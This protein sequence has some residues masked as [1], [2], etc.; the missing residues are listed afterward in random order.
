[1]NPVPGS[2][3]PTSREQ[4]GKGPQKKGKGE[5][6]NWGG[7][8]GRTD[9]PKRETVFKGEL[10]APARES[11]EKKGGGVLLER[12]PGGTGKGVNPLY[13]ARAES[14]VRTKKNG[15]ETNRNFLSGFIK[16]EGGKL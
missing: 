5:L 6:N 12:A 3:R 2:K 16:K 9:N 10:R 7:R 13:H 1:M 4:T 8:E 11:T 14:G 15:G